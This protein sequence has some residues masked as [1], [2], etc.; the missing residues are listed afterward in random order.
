[1]YKCLVYIFNFMKQCQCV[2]TFLY[3][4]L[5]YIYIYTCTFLC[6]IV[7]VLHELRRRSFAFDKHIQEQYLL[8]IN[9]K[10]IIM[11]NWWFSWT[12]MDS[13]MASVLYLK[14]TLDFLSIS[15]PHR[16]GISSSWQD[17]AAK[18]D[19]LEKR[20]LKDV[21]DENW[22]G[23]SWLDSAWKE[24]HQTVSGWFVRFVR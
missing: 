5:I 8:Y 12:V 6:E 22:T 9:T 13:Y 7:N 14:Y 11:K 10:S 21:E 20:L 24:E 4:N 17:D 23:V 15:D 2:C 19:R 18:L 1:M 3:I 16:H